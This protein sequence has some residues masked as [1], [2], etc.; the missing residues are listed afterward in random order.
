MNAPQ[1]PPVGAF[2]R[3]APR[4]SLRASGHRARVVYLI[5]ALLVAG[6]VF[7]VLSP[8]PSAPLRK[9]EGVDPVPQP[10]PAIAAPE[11][12]PPPSPRPDQLDDRIAELSRSFEDLG[13]RFSAIEAQLV[14]LD[15]RNDD[16]RTRLEALTAPPRPKP[17]PARRAAGAKPSKPAGPEPRMPTVLSI[18]T[19]GSKPSV[20]IRDP[21][22]NL[23]FYREGDA[24]G[25]AR[26]ERIDSQARRVHLRLPDGTVTAVDA[27][28]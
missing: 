3:F 11:P 4:I 20:A 24:V 21:Q 14:A 12:P 19:W 6:A 26:I 7:L 1:T 17:E 8:S 15:E 9:P 16:I 25:I 2:S 28:N 5:A 22:G 27:K 10:L 13:A 23:A 18:D